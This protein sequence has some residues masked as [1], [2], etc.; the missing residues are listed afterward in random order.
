MDLKI[1][2]IKFE[3]IAQ[4]KQNAGEW[5][6]RMNLTDA[7]DPIFGDKWQGYPEFDKERVDYYRSFFSV[8]DGGTAEKTT[9]IPEEYLL[10]KNCL[11]ET[12]VFPEPMAQID[13]NGQP[14]LDKFGRMRVKTSVVVLTRKRLEKMDNSYRYLKG[15]SC[16]EKGQSLIG[17]LYAP[18]REFQ[19]ATFAPVAGVAAPQAPLINGQNA[20]APA[21]PAPMQ[22]Q[23]TTEQP[24]PQAAPQPAPMQ[25]AF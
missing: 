1:T 23:S 14:L 22:P 12:F 21:Q 16:E 6:M 5:F 13:Q 19:T 4:G 25:P 17:R 18:L 11:A 2:N 7:E 15:Q 20:P 8:A 9:P 10:L 3:Q 24:A